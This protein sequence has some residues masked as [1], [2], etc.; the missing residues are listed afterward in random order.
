MSSRRITALLR[1]AAALALVGAVL[2]TSLPA[3]A[4]W[5]WEEDF[6]PDLSGAMNVMGADSCPNDGSELED[7]MNDLIDAD[8]TL[9]GS[10]SDCQDDLVWS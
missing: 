6:A 2:G 4:S 10:A 8:S 7:W 3:F 1:P 5:E 9:N